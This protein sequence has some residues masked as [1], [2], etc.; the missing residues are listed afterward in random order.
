MTDPDVI[1]THART[2]AWADA[3]RALH[4]AL[5]SDAS[6]SG[7]DRLDW[8]ASTLADAFFDD[9]A[10]EGA[11]R[12]SG[13]VIASALET[14]VLLHSGG[15]FRLGGERF[16]TAVSTLV[17]QRRAEGDRTAARRFARFRPD[18]PACAAVLRDAP[19]SGGE[20][21]G[22]PGPTGSAREPNTPGAADVNLESVEHAHPHSDVVT[23]TSTAPSTASDRSRSLFRSPVEAAFFQAVR[24]VFPTYLPIPNAAL[25]SVLD[26]DALKPHLTAPARQLLYT[27]TVDC[28]LVDPGAVGDDASDAMRPVAFFELDSTYHDAPDRKH[29]DTLKDE[30][31]AAAGHRLVR[32]RPHAP[33]VNVDAFASILRSLYRDAPVRP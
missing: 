31:V 28:V 4:V 24:H 32:L 22:A 25:S 12:R 17:A 6:A 19:A 3:W 2:G 27:S 11:R 21:D 30:I 5:T 29:N 9:L 10:S 8:A 16:D 18:L 1:L 7:D 23:V 14:V 33:D 15:L 26:T 20:G 13:D